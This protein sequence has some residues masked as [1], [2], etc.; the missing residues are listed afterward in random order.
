MPLC[1]CLFLSLYLSLFLYVFSIYIHISFLFLM[2]NYFISPHIFFIICCSF[3]QLLFPFSFCCCHLVTKSCPTLCEPMVCSPPGS[4]V[5][6]I[7]QARILEQVTIPSSRG[8]SWPRD[9]TP[10]FC[11][12]GRFFTTDHQGSPFSL[13]GLETYLFESPHLMILHLPPSRLPG[14]E[15]S[16]GLHSRLWYWDYCRSNL[17]TMSILAQDLDE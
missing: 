9:W 2:Y 14:P 10:V 5:L 11:I 8:S 3:Y 12:A 17:K 1:L 13:R 4:A 15:S 6:G 16:I 7:S